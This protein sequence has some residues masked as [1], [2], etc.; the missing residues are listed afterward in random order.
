MRR[1]ILTAGCLALAIGA[2]PAQPSHTIVKPDTTKWGAGPPALPPGAKSAV[3][4]GDPAK[5]QLFVLRLW[6]PKG[7]RIPP[8]THPRPELVT[9]VSGSGNLGFGKVADRAKTER[10]PTGTFTAMPPNT[11]H[12]VFIDEDTV[13]QLSTIGPWA[14]NYVNPADDPRKKPK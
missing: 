12:Y 5:P 4:Y 11:P 10:L 2:A 6:L 13:V 7:Y 9:L 14:V 8:H 1:L 3:L